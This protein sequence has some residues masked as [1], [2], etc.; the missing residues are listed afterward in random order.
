VLLINTGE[1]IQNN[2]DTN[3]KYKIQK[4]FII[5]IYIFIFIFIFI[6]GQMQTPGCI[7]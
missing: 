6:Y 3:T 7:K 5:Y 4:G 1:E 2:S